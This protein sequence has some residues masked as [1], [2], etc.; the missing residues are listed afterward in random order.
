MVL[1]SRAFVDV[2]I[3]PANFPDEIFRTYVENFDTNGDRVLSD[4]EIAAVTAID[5]N[6]KGIGIAGL[7]GIKSFTSL[8]SLNCE[9]NSM[10]A[11][12]LSGMTKLKEVSFAGNQSL[13][14]INISGTSITTIDLKGSD[15]LVR[16]KN[17]YATECT[18]LTSLKIAGVSNLEKLDVK[19]CNNLQVL[20]CNNNRLEALD[21]DSC[22]DSLKELQCSSNRINELDV[23]GFTSLEILYCYY[24]YQLSSLNVSGCTS[25][26][27]LWCYSGNL[28]ALDVR[29]CD[30]LENLNCNYNKLVALDINPSISSSATYNYILQ[31]RSRD[32][33]QNSYTAGVYYYYNF[34]KIIPEEKIQ[35]IMLTSVYAQ[36]KEQIISSEYKDGIIYIKEDKIPDTIHYEYET[37]HEERRLAIDLAISSQAQAVNSPRITTETLASG[38]QGIAYTA[39]IEVSPS[40][41]RPVSWSISAGVL[42]EGLS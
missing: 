15:N 18:S 29:S 33:V 42:P 4:A 9:N 8:E 2:P 13:E 7:E 25:L 21:L 11:L 26:K 28:S 19:G 3:T 38:V 27:T 31:N 35:G 17:F 22:K 32:V 39:R 41:T 30:K 20:Y 12:D 23:S 34:R 6:N 14:T 5:V 40:T 37:G 10:M 1:C 24:N 36:I 16:L